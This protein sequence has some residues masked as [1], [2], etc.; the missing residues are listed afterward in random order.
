MEAINRGEREKK[1]HSHCQQASNVVQ[2]CPKSVH[3]IIDSTEYSMKCNPS[4][5][6]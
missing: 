4:M 3:Y 1:K 5:V 6:T 2:N